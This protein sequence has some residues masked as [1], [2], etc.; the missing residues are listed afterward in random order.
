[1][2]Y[3]LSRFDCMKRRR[4]KYG[5]EKRALSE[6]ARLFR[7]ANVRRRR[8]M[9]LEARENKWAMGMVRKLRNGAGTRACRPHRRQKNGLEIYNQKIT[10]VIEMKMNVEMPYRVSIVIEDEDDRKRLLK[11]MARGLKP[12]AVGEAEASAAPA[13]VTRARPPKSEWITDEKLFPLLK[14]MGQFTVADVML[15]LDF[16]VNKRNKRRFAAR[17]THLKMDGKIERTSAAKRYAKGFQKPLRVYAW[18]NA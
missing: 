11:F 18:L 2:P 3:S 1:M 7:R 9:W 5:H 17:L 14:A 10:E 4:E 8:R 13:H 12:D 16:P 15:K 6:G